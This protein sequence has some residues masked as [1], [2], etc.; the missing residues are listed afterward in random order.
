[1]ADQIAFNIIRPFE[2]GTLNHIDAEHTAL[3]N[4]MYEITGAECG[5]RRLILNKENVA[6][7]D[8]L[9]M[10]DMICEAKERAGD[11]MKYT[12]PISKYFNANGRP[13]KAYIPSVF[14]I[15]SLYAFN[16]RERK[17]SELEGQM[18]SNREVRE[19][20]QFY[21][22]CLNRMEKYNITIIAINHIKSKVE[23][24]QYAVT[25]PQLMLLKPGESLPRGQAPIYLAQN[26]F[27]CNATKGNMYTREEDGFDGMKVTLQ[28]T[29]TKTSFI[30]STISVCFNKKI[31]FDPVY[32][33]F[34]YAVDNGL[35]EGRN[36]YLYVKGLDTFKF[37]RKDFRHKFI[38]DAPFRNEFLE[39]TRPYLESLLG[40]KEI[41]K[42]E[43]LKY[44]SIQSLTEN[45]DGDAVAGP[46]RV[47]ALP[48]KSK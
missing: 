13:V 17:D 31:G 26:V 35:I 41:T 32:T 38:N 11:E 9:D 28:V 27:R 5:D 46:E 36:P 12:I 29:K 18:S 44:A 20:S 24:N 43:E 2:D 40:T 16:S 48:S 33:M 21:S 4:R 1:L 19:V 25:P 22:K 3:K 15:D 45:E 7:E 6:I 39:I 34:E 42:G 30:G 47:I 37:N 10:I 8:V 14:I 23:V